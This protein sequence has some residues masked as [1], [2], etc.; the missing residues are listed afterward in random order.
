MLRL[1]TPM[2]CAFILLFSN[3]ALFITQILHNESLA[4][5]FSRSIK[6]SVLAF[7]IPPYCLLRV[8]FVSDMAKLEY[9]T[10]VNYTFILW[11][12]PI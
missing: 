6:S 8:V 11:Q 4:Y 10:P 2:N 1:Y 3:A 9:S 12:R 5:S 7:H